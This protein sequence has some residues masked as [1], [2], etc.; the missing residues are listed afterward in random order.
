MYEAT[1]DS[2]AEMMDREI[3]L[4]VY[5]DKLGRLHDAI[6]RIPGILLDIAC[7]SG[8]MLAMYRSRFDPDRMLI[9]V[10]ISPKM[11]ALSKDRLDDDCKVLVGDMRSLP[12]IGSAK[13]AGI[14]NFF[15]IHHLDPEALQTALHEWNRVMIPKGRLL[16]AAWEGTGTIDYGEESEMVA[17]RYASG[18]LSEMAS[19]AGFGVTGY[20]VEPVEGFPM[21]AVYLECTKD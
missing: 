19:L 8:Q 20:T 13:V 11:V 17:L 7:G 5:R 15:A 16:I 2:Y 3:G 6:A 12:F 1:A 18:V 4:P 14:I 10:D 21:D 9:G